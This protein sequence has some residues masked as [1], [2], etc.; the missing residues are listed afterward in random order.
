MSRVG[1]MPIEIPSDVK[2]TV[3]KGVV[4]VEG[5][6]GRLEQI[7]HPS[8]IVKT[9]DGSLT[10]Q[11]PSESKMY[12]SLHGLTRTLLSNMVEGVTRGHQK[13]LEINGVGYR[14]DLQG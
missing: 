10:V 9:E 6:K 13:N 12:K 11:R 2:V 3:D 8:M 5:P 7:I 14:A 1:R 4:A